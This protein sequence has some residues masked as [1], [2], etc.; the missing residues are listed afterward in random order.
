M[1]V[2]GLSRRFDR[3]GASSSRVD[4]ANVYEMKPRRFGGAS[5]FL[6]RSM[7]SGSPRCAFAIV[8][9]RRGA[10]I[11][12][13]PS[14]AIESAAHTLHW[15]LRTYRERIVLAVSFGGLGG[16]VLIDIA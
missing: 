16:L 7:R 9:N 8:P 6:P 10:P 12:N 11:L 14:P 15:A 4:V 3:I 2:Y 13:T 5:F 1:L